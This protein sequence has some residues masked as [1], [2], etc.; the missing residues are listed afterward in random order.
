MTRSQNSDRFC[1]WVILQIT[2]S[3]IQVILQIRA[4]GPRKVKVERSQAGGLKGL[5]DYVDD[6]TSVN[7]YTA[8]RRVSRYSNAKAKL[9][10][11]R[12]KEGACGE[13]LVTIRRVGGSIT[14]R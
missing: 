6:G 11:P 10:T 8:S 4:L 5:G 13:F 9:A 7:G 12:S 2:T 1:L 14:T 3:V